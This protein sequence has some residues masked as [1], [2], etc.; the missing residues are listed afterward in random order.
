[1]VLWL[2]FK[3]RWRTNKLL[4]KSKFMRDG[5]G[6]ALAVKSGPCSGQFS[7]IDVLFSLNNCSEL[8]NDELDLVILASIQAFTHCESSGTK[9]IRS[10]ACSFYYQSVPICKEMFLLFF[11]LSDARFRQLN[12]HYQVTVCR[13]ELMATRRHRSASQEG[14]LA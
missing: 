1:M 7:E 11:R 5:C 10:P 6:C 4:K 2:R 14:F 13:S 9:Q 8:S 3:E 12:E